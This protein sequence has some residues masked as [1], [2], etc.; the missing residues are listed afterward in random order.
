MNRDA[1]PRTK[2]T[3]VKDPLTKALKADFD[4]AHEAGK[5]ALKERDFEGVAKVVERERKLIQQQRAR[6]DTQLAARPHRPKK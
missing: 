4:A 2:R 6:L 5:R 1:S 3:R